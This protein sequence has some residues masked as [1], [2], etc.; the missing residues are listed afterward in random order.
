M[1]TSA[2][3]GEGPRPEPEPRSELVQTTDHF[4][5][6][7]VRSK[8]TF[9]ELR[10]P[11]EDAEVARE[12]IGEGCDVRE[13]RFDAETWLVESVLVPRHAAE[14]GAEAEALTDAL[15]DRIES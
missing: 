14:D 9:A 2:G 3:T 4:Y 11:P 12:V 5:H 6:V 7:R 8:E 13:G 15:V 1:A 10:T